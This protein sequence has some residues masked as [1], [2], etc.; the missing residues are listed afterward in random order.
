LDLIDT[1]LKGYVK[2]LDIIKE[3]L[4]EIHQRIEPGPRARR[5]AISLTNLET[6]I[7]WLAIR[8]SEEIEKDESN[9]GEF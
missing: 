3:G 9:Q 7:L 2:G 1:E 4:R 6:A 5:V 8:T